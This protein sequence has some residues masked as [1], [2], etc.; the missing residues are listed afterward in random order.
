MFDDTWRWD[1]LDTAWLGEID[2]RNAPLSTVIATARAVQGDGTA[3][4]LTM[5]GVRLLEMRRILKSTGSIYLHCDPTAGHY[6][7]LAMDAV[8]GRDAFRNEIQWRRYGSHNDVR[9]GSRHFGRVHDTILFYS[10]SSKPTWSQ[11]FVPHDPEYVQST[12]RY[13]DEG[14]GRRYA[15]TPMTGPG[16]E[17]KGNPV[18]EWNGHTRAWRYSRETIEELDRKGLIHYSRTGYARRK[19]FLDESRGVPVQDVW[20]DIRSL[21]GRHK[22]RTGWQTQ[23]PLALLQ[24]IVKASSDRNDLVLDPFCGCATACVAAEIEG[25]QWIGID[26]CVAAED[27][28]RVR[29]SDVALDWND[30]LLRVT[31]KPPVRTDMKSPVKA[32]R[33]LSQYRTD[34]NIDKLYGEQRGDCPG[35]GNHYHS[36]D[37]HVDHVVPVAQDGGDE[38]ANLQLLCG[39]CNSKK[40]AGTMVDLWDR[41]V[42]DAVVTKDVAGA[43]RKRWR[44]RRVKSN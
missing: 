5:M 36:K 44:E 25:R 9:Q 38:L 27:I 17:A 24:R 19:L 2:R 41:L 34:E 26:A 20:T 11:Q 31:R 4:Y 16:G 15:T 43:L 35:C 14:S 8:F 6:L 10:K 40:S 32:I 1:E 33:R 29:L 23:K 37:M 21:S 39:H 42:K 13:V 22:E 30:T 7:K 12:Y 18:F 3:A 28:T